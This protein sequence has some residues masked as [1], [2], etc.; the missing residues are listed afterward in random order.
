[1]QLYKAII[2]PKTAFSSTIQGDTLFGYMCWEYLNAFGEA[3]LTTLLA[4]YAQNPPFVVS[5]AVPSG[6]IHRPTIPLSFMADI[7][8]ENRKKLKKSN[9]IPLS[10]LEKPLNQ[11]GDDLTQR[12]TTKS[13]TRMHNSINRQTASTTGDGFDPYAQKLLYYGTGVKNTEKP[14]NTTL[15]IYICIDTALIDAHTV[16]S[17]L[18]AVGTMGYGASKTRGLGKFD[19]D[20]FAEYAFA[21]H[22][23]SNA[24]LTLASHYPEQN[25]YTNQTYYK[26]ITKFGKHGDVGALHKNHHKSPVLGCATGAIMTPKTMDISRLYIGM[27]MGGNGQLSAAIPE[28]VHQA[29]TPIV[30]IYHTIKTGETKS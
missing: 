15:D 7:N 28:T 19:I 10:T 8:G 21:T 18:S 20:S 4:Q 17:L 26:T 5:D 27:G 11:W 14:Q 30:P 2:R 1:M 23:D 6:H 3:K 22:P 16:Q 24:Y 12:D 25:T 9:Y 13:F 29:Y